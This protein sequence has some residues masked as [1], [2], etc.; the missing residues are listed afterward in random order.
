MRIATFFLISFLL[1]GCSE[2]SQRPIEWKDKT[3]EQ[4]KKESNYWRSC[5]VKNHRTKGVEFCNAEFEK[6]F[7]Y[8]YKNAQKQ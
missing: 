1:V 3:P 8:P 2:K 6:E 5:Y 4:Q 7:G